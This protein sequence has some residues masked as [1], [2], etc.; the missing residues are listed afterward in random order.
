LFSLGGEGQI[1]FGAM[2]AGLVALFV[3]G[4]PPLLHVLLA[5]AVGSAVGFLWALIPGA[6]RAYLGANEL[7]STLMLNPIALAIY[8]FILVQIKPAKENFLV[9]A[10]FPDS[11]VLLRF[12]PTT[13]V[14][15]AIIFV[16]LAVILVWLLIQRTPLGYEI[17][18]VGFNP[19]FARY[20]GINIKRTILLSMGISGLLAGLTGS[21]L[22]LGVYQRLNNGISAGLTFEGIVVALLARNNPLAVPAMALMY[23]YL[24]V[25]AQFMQ[26][27]AGVSLEIVRV[28]QAIIILLF[29]AEG[30]T[31]F[32]RW[33]RQAQA[34]REA[35]AAA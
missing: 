19:R 4:L 33:R 29:T 23:A 13:R 26:N 22:A 25:G 18:M 30:L 3:Q 7:V 28:I 17:R 2:G 12:I 15:I 35:P 5:I 31:E 10:Q 20:G 24:R 1:F 8:E 14:N 11:A 16:V 34:T 21:Y 32:L 6:L 9:S 27:D